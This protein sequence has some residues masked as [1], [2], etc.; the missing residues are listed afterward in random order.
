M[1]GR[2]LVAYGNASNYVATTAEYLACICRY[3]EWEVHYV[4]VTHGAEIA[5]DLNDY[6]A[7]FQSYCARLT[8]GLLSPD[9]IGKLKEFRGV[10]V[11]SVQDEY[12]RTSR[13]RQA[14]GELGYHV[15]LTSV[16][17]ALVERI[18]PPELFPGT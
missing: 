9:Y 2:L 10:K 13:L 18:F 17:P 8:E 7:I 16:P 3:S 6:D 12:E 14:I 5:F 11:L 4:H 1:S 15:V